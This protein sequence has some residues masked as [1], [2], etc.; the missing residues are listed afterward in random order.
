[1]AADHQNIDEIRLAYASHADMQ[2]LLREY[3][4]L[5]QAVQHWKDMY[6]QANQQRGNWYERCQA[7]E[8]Q[9]AQTI[10]EYNRL[11]D[12]AEFQRCEREYRS[13]LECTEFA[14]DWLILHHVI[15]TE[16]ADWR[17]K[18]DGSPFFRCD[19]S[20]NGGYMDWDTNAYIHTERCA[21]GFEDSLPA[22]HD[23]IRR[24]LGKD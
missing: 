16:G 9:L 14:L 24:A 11:A 18:F 19:C 8:R 15:E 4:Y 23:Q 12:T 17:S 7:A 5:E 22:L 1:M 13:L 2:W 3:D 21:S 10:D 20:E 6:E